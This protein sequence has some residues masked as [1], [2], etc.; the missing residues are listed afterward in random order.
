VSGNESPI[1]TNGARSEG[2]T[3]GTGFGAL[4][5]VSMPVTVEIGRTRLTIEE[6]LALDAGS[7]VELDRLAG[8]PVDVY[9]GERRMAEGEVVVIE[10]RLGVRITRV[11]PQ[12]DGEAR[13]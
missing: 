13:S 11:L 5:D 1:E 9:I 8:E 4:L 10:D 3:R 7:V 2:A 12:P 6:V